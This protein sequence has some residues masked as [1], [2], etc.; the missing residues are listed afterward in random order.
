MSSVVI[1][2]DTSGTVTVTVPAVAGTNTV[3][4][5][6][7][8]GTPVISGQ[9][10]AITAGTSVT[11]SGTGVTFSNIPSWVKRIT[12][13]LD[14]VVAGGSSAFLVQIGTGGTPS[15]SNYNSVVWSAS[16]N[17]SGAT[18]GFILNAGSTGTQ[19]YTGSLVLN[20]ITGNE[21]VGTSLFNNSSSS[22]G[23]IGSLQTGRAGLS[24]VLNLV[25]VTT[26][27]GTDVFGGGTINILYE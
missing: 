2:G 15:T 17:Y 5:P 12:V 8:T 1:S 16:V 14:L 4:I 6:A 21:W 24:G 7:V 26:S 3:T 10:S 11:A 19:T 25:K 13:M 20:N 18:N 22:G 27:N 23:S 9:N